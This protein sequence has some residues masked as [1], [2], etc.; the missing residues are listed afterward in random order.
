MLRILTS[1]KWLV[2]LLLSALYSV[3]AYNL[4]G[5]QW[6]RHQDKST[7]ADAINE[8]YSAPARPLADVVDE[9]PPGP[10]TEWTRVTMTGTYEADTELFVR[11]RPMHQTNGYEVLVPFDTDAGTILIDRGWVAYGNT[12]QEIPDVP[13]APAGQVEVTGWVRAS[14]EPRDH[15]LPAG[16]LAS[17]NVDEAQKQ[18]EA[19]LLPAYV[20]LESEQAHSDPGA[21]PPRPEPLEPP[22]TDLGSHLAYAIQWWMTV[23]L[24]FILVFFGVRAEH[25]QRLPRKAKPK[26]VR[27]WDE[28]D[29]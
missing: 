7:K 3:L 12:A 29:E 14:H 9:L 13:A 6:H 2:A 16:Q 11:N 20:V 8:H 17:L 1:R 24:G 19:P 23:P 22:S 27:I 18:V 25:R 5:W 10:Q 4:G 28:E 26:K 15:H 21:T